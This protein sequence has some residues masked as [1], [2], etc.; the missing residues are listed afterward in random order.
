MIAAVKILQPP[1]D[2]LYDLLTDEQK[3]RLTGLAQYRRQSAARA[4]AQT[5]AAVTPTWRSAAIERTIRPSDAQKQDLAAL[6]AAAAGATETLKASC[7]GEMPLTA[8]AQL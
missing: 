5:C 1:L 2:K 4:V 7:S 8:P 6:T 3:A